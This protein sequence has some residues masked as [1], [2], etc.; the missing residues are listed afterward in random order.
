V[1]VCRTYGSQSVLTE[2]SADELLIDYAHARFDMSWRMLASIM[3]PAY[4]Y[5]DGGVGLPSSASFGSQRIR[6]TAGQ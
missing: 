3:V 1:R 6:F 4:G 2:Y 5:G